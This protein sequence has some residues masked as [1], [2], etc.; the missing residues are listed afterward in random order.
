MPDVIPVADVLAVVVTIFTGCDVEPVVVGEPIN[1]VVIIG[2][3]S[4][5][6]VLRS[7]ESFDKRFTNSVRISSNRPIRCDIRCISSLESTFKSRTVAI[8]S[9]VLDCS[10]KPVSY[11]SA[12]A[13]ILASINS[14][15]MEDDFSRCSRCVQISLSLTC[16]SSVCLRNDFESSVVSSIVVCLANEADVPVVSFCD[17]GNTYILFDLCVCKN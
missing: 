10:R 12:A 16:R 6:G 15:S 1:V 17:F 9:R 7:D 14:R 8:K 4:S 5:A 13:A 11:V 2:I 3:F